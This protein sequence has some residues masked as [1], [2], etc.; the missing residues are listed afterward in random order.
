VLDEAQARGLERARA[1]AILRELAGDEI[2]V[3]A[4]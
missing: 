2:V 3:A 4:D 1:L